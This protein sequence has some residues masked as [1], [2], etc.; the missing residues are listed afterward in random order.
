VVTSALQIAGLK[1]SFHR[2]ALTTLI[3]KRFA[4]TQ[5]TAAQSFPALFPSNLRWNQGL[6]VDKKWSGMITA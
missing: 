1:C 2:I 6:L 4:C 5:K 3:V